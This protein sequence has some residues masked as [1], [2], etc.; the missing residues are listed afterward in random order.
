MFTDDLMLQD[1]YI[2]FAER[3]LGIDYEDYIQMMNDVEQFLEDKETE[4]Q[5][6]YR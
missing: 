4:Y 1:D 6:A 5:L 3:Y 2:N